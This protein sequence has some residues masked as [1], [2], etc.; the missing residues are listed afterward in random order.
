MFI[1]S[2]AHLSYHTFEG[3]RE[4]VIERAY[5]KEVKYILA[6]GTDLDSSGTSLDI[7]HKHENIFS[8]VGV[9]PHDAQSFN[10]DVKKS[11]MELIR[12]EKVVAIGEIGLDYYRNN[13]PPEVQKRVFA[14]QLR[15]ARETGLPVI[16]HVRDA[17][18]DV[19]EVIDSVNNS[20]VRGVFHCY[21]GDL[22]TARRL[23]KKGFFVSFGG[24]ITFKNY[25]HVEMLEEIQIEKMLIETDCPFLAPEPFRGRRSEPGYVPLVAVRLAD[26]K[27][28]SLEDVG[29]ITAFNANRLFGI[30]PEMEEVKIVYQIRDSLYVNP[31]LRCTA[32]C[33]FCA[34][35]IDPVVKGHNLGLAVEDEPTAK[36]AIQLI[37]DPT[38]YS[39]VVFCGYGEPT[40]RLDFIKEV[41]RWLKSKGAK[42]RLNTDGHGNL[43]YDRNIVP[44]LVGIIDEVSLSINAHTAE[45]YQ[46]IMR[47]EYGERSFEATLDFV[48]KCVASG[49]KTVLTIVDIPGINIEECTKLARGLGAEF[50]VRKYNEVG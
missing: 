37:G 15:I 11:M 16:I 26:I 49:I 17:W 42:V 29:R 33:V 4:E 6:I 48:R 44:E 45:Q 21:S 47:T 22:E 35:L 27:G 3:D 18:N 40:L 41:S 50:R 1:D 20:D 30:A 8:T 32:D 24:I 46:K 2:H 38:R 14:K 12:D 19:E 34:R 25:K 23:I 36:Q 10:D 39:E 7:A 9:H 13:S 5:D 31:T 43:I 28:L